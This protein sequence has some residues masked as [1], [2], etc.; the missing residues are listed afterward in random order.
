MGE[1]EVLA[2]ALDD[3]A[4]LARVLAHMANVLRI[5]G[6]L[7][8]AI[9]A[10]QQ[11]LTLA[12]ALGDS[13]LQEEA[14]CT[15]GQAYGAIGDYGRG[16]ELLRRNVEAADQA[17]GTP[18]TNVR[19]GSQAWLARPLGRLG[20]FAEGRRHGEEALRLATLAGRGATPIVAHATLGELYLAQGDLEPAIRVLEQGLALCRAS[21]NRDTLQGIA[22]GLGAATA[23]VGFYCAYRFDMPLGPAEV[24]V[25]SLV[26]VIVAAGDAVRRAVGKWQ[27]I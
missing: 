19:I 16:A 24:A 9:A 1:A 25:A 8:G 11:A 27:V 2:R 15:L 7:D 23:F 4:R 10:G 21:D 12:A 17:S 3:R 13:A 22:A 5:T 26:L 20:A 6:D 14:S 18:R